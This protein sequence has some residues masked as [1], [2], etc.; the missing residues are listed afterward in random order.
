MNRKTSCFW[1]LLCP[2]FVG[3]KNFSERQLY[4]WSVKSKLY[5][6]IAIATILFA[7]SVSRVLIGFVQPCSQGYRR[8]ELLRRSGISKA[9]TLLPTLFDSLT[10]Y[11]WRNLVYIYKY[12]YKLSLCRTLLIQGFHGTL[13][14]SGTIYI[15]W[16]YL[17]KLL[18]LNFSLNRVKSTL[19]AVF[20]FSSR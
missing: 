7:H 6:T 4:Y 17:P 10:W 14:I 12:L 20:C 18:W 1:V 3:W 8:N 13:N 5:Y 19:N 16:S 15:Y 2:D 11:I 9:D